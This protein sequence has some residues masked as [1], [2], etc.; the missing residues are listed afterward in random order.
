[1]SFTGSA[2]NTKTALGRLALVAGE[3]DLPIRVAENATAEGWH[4]TAFCL[5]KQNQGALKQFSPGGILSISPGLVEKNLSLGKQHEITHVVFA[6]KVN[7][8]ILFTNPRMDK[9]AIDIL[10]ALR[11]CNDDQVMVQ[12]I[13]YL[14]NEGYQIL[15][16]TQFLT[17]LF[18]GSQCFSHA[19]PTETDW[20]DIQY[21]FEIA[22]EMGRLDVGQTVVIR[23]K[24]IL[25]VEAIEGTDECIRRAGRWAK[26]K[27]GIVVK[28]AKPEQDNRF[29]VPTV[30]LRTLKRIHESGLH[31]LATEANQTFYLDLPEMIRFANQKKMLLLSLSREEAEQKTIL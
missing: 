31:G 24:M 1:M 10:Q 19:Q 6:G 13:A 12:I 23:N 2:E 8:W 9:R 22:S 29:D 4:V 28:L 21:G 27:G 11:R 26:K 14:A 17:E 7:K 16:Q 3:G 15:P 20:A 5:S 18:H 25:A 30:G